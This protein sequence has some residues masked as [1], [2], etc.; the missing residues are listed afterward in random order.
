MLVIPIKINDCETIV[1]GILNPVHIYQSGP[2]KGKL[3]PQAFQS[4]VGKDEVSTI[5]HHY[6]GDDFCKRKAKEIN[7]GKNQ[8]H[9]LAVIL[10][11]KVRSAGSYLEDSRNPPNY[12]GHA[13]IKHGFISVPPDDPLSGNERLKQIDHIKR[14]VDF[15][16]YYADPDPDSCEWTGPDLIP[17]IG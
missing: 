14:L 5:R 3:K 7:S 11:E 15:V 2:R 16:K 9:G 13:D 10:A 8:Y 12:L 1:R 17:E 6:M 4:P